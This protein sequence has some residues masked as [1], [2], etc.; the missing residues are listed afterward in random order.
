MTKKVQ[1]GHQIKDDKKYFK[2]TKKF[3]MKDDLRNSKFMKMFGFV[4]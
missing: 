2:T 3:T 1:N 4:Y